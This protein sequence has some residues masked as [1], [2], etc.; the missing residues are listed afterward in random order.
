MIKLSEEGMKARIGQKL[1]L[2][3]QTVSQVVKAKEKFLKE[4]SSATPV[5]T[6]MIRKQ[7]SLIADMEKVLE[8][9]IE[10][11]ISHNIPLNQS[12]I[13][14]KALNLF[15]SMKAQRGE[16]AAEEKSKANSVW[17]IRFKERSHLHNIKVQGEAARADVKAAASYP[18]HLAEIIN[19][20]KTAF[21]WK[22]MPCRTHS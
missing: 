6:Q 17:F 3:S 11:Q 15:N 10:D 9:W 4:S 20:D 5:N 18:E 14:S 8:V 12:L 21:Y 13:Q 2:L 16:E 19:K 22:K 7:N 1:G